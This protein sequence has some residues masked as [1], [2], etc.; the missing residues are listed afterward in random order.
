MSIR[1]VHRNKKGK[2]YEVRYFNN[3]G[4][5][6]SKTFD[7]RNE[8]ILFDKQQS[9][10]KTQGSLINY[11][12]GKRKLQEIFEEW[13][14]PMNGKSPKSLVEIHSLWSIHVKPTFGNRKINSI[15]TS[16]IRKWLI[17]AEK[18]QLSSDRRFRALKN[19]FVRLLDHS[20]DMG[21][22]TRNVARGSNGRVI[23]IG[24]RIQKIN[25]IKRV[26]SYNELIKLVLAS[27]EFQNLILIMGVLGP[28]WAE[29][30][31][32]KKKDF[33][34]E[35]N[36]VLIER[37]LSEVNGKF[38][39]KSTKT[40]QVRKLPLPEFI[41]NRVLTLLS[42]LNDEDYLFVNSKGGPISISNFTKRVFQPA[43]EKANL[44]KAT[45][46]DLRT[47]A[48]SLMIQM[49]EPITVISKI[50]G[51]SNPNTTL[52]HYAELFP[53]DFSNTANRLDELFSNSQLRK[54]YGNQN[55]IMN[56]G[57]EN[58]DSA[59][60]LEENLSGPC[61]DRTDDPQIKSLLL[62]RLS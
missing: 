54:N 50:A 46:K 10:A 32:L 48:V 37:S 2:G 25:K 6:L 58:T 47:T 28:R 52:K 24:N 36:L 53:S 21:Y 23:N 56:Q 17:D 8:A 26:F 12:E 3:D 61:R 45:I 9:I 60:F 41:K 31:A 29:T 11:S 57:L 1:I 40:N 16:E 49:G 42:Q 39:L 51:H 38:F 22:I 14:I 43:L 44:G 27:G 55:S 35:N 59:L 5:L 7:D 62:Y 33:D 4:R 34:L 20:V 30:I 13:I 15:K 19:V 18:Q